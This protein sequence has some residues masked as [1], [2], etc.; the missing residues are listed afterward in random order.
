MNQTGHRKITAA[1]KDSY[2]ILLLL[3]ILCR[4]KDTI[5]LIHVMAEKM[6]MA[7]GQLLYD[8]IPYAQSQGRGRTTIVNAVCVGLSRGAKNYCPWYVMILKR[9]PAN[10]YTDQIITDVP[11]ICPTEATIICR[12]LETPFGLTRHVRVPLAPKSV[13]FYLYLVVVLL[14]VDLN[15]E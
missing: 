6:T 7:Y 1:R 8:T 5:H 12:K 14:R 13:T 2:T 11:G 15:E 9:F 3:Y 10:T 4:Q